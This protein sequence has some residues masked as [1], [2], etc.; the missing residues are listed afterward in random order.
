MPNL[1][2]ALTILVP[3]ALGAEPDSTKQMN[4][5]SAN[6]QIEVLFSRAANGSD[7]LGTLLKSGAVISN[8]G[9]P[10]KDMP[11]IIQPPQGGLTF[12]ETVAQDES[13]KV[14]LWD[15]VFFSNGAK[16]DLDLYTDELANIVRSGDG[17]GG[18][19]PF[20]IELTCDSVKNPKTAAR[21]YRQA[22]LRIR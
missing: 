14:P 2:F 6:G 8:A 9:Q 17:A 16:P 12:Y 15:V 19:N 13:G 18:N 20:L 10:M 11:I 3:M 22:P 4:C 1:L 21:A 5:K 7:I